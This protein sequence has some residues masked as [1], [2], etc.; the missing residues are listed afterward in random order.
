MMPRAVRSRGRVDYDPFMIDPKVLRPKAYSDGA[1]LM[2][3]AAW[4]PSTLEYS[5]REIVRLR[6]AGLNGCRY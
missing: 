4:A 2:R 5:V 6:S 1:T 3:D